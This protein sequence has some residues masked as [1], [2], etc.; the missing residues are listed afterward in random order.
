M[1]ERVEIAWRFDSADVLK[2][3]R[4]NADVSVVGMEDGAMVFRTTGS[5]PILEYLPLLNLPALPHQAVE[6]EMKA[7]ISGVAELFWSN[8]TQ[9]PYGG[10][11]PEKRTE[12]GVRGDG[13]WHTYR[14][15]PFWQKE[16][17]I[18][19]LRFDPYGIGEFHL[20]AIRVIRLEGVN[21]REGQTKFLFRGGQ[22]D[23]LP[24]HGVEMQ[25]MSNGTRWRLVEPDG[26][27]GGCVNVGAEQNANVA[28]RLRSSRARRCSLIFATSEAYGLQQHT[29][30]LLP[31]GKS[32]L[33]NIDMLDAR[34]W[35]GEVVLL[36]IRPGERVGDEVVLEEVQVSSQPLGSPQLHVLFFGIEDAL[37]RTQTPVTVTLRTV[38]RGGQPAKGLRAVIRLPSAARLVK[39]LP[40]EATDQLFGEEREWRWLVSFSR[41]V[42]GSLFAQIHASNAPMVRTDA[43]VEVT[44]RLAKGRAGMVPPPTPVTPKCPVGVYYFPGWRTAGQW[45]PISRFPERKP[46]LGWYREGDSRIADWHIKWAVEH[47]ITFFVYDWYWV[48]GARQLEHALHE[49][50]FQS[51]YRRYLQFCLLW[52]NHNPPNTSSYEDCIAVTRFWIENY[53]GRPEHLRIDGKPVMI[54]FS[55][56]RLRADMGSDAVKRAFD[57]MREECIRAG[58]NGLYLIAC[59]GSTGEAQTAAQEGY[60]AVTAYN[61]PHLGMVGDTKWAP[62][63]TLVEGYRQQWTAIVSNSPI[64]LLPPVSGGWDSR[65]WHG[66]DAVVRYGRTPQKFKKHLG[67][68]LHFI[69]SNRRRV[70]P[71]ILIEAWNEWGEGSYVEPHKEFGFGYLDAIREVCTSAPKTRVD[72]TPADVG[73]VPPQVKMVQTTKPQW[74]FARD[75]YGWDNGMNLDN[76]RIEN[77]ALTAVT[78]GNDPA[79]FGPPMQIASTRYRRLRLRMRLEPAQQQFD[80]L[81]QVFWSTRSLA[82]S[83]S[84][85]VRFQVYVDNRWRDYTLNLSENPR[86]RGTITRLRLDPC[87]RSGV[88]V[89]IARIEL[90]P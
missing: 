67:D 75:T 41:P 3:W 74:E 77:G 7:D 36:G 59:I 31:D 27:A 9:S 63:D 26:F 22:V 51:R 58:L 79:F 34:G 86:W 10:F 90:L 43:P 66:Q 65:P 2:E 44:L 88:R 46:V 54:I 84:T 23:W 76:P 5:D 71:M 47:G 38:N 52:A 60:D 70:V 29:F 16:R 24:W 1:R 21:Q 14:V 87:T 4:A 6:I 55:P 49:G 85:S 68:A 45:V 17:R 64:P 80:D 48:Q 18:I 19:R 53:F 28:V 32:H 57:A 56:Y 50:Y 13:Q 89:Q 81:G 82:E 73:F 83:E 39:T 72:L 42:R 11:A 30:E 20:R 12:F 25:A 33:Y 35:A 15:F 8:T 78:T 40:C 69:H 62:F 37:P 61:W